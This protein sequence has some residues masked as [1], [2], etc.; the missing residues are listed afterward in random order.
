MISPIPS[1]SFTAPTAPEHQQ[2]ELLKQVTNHA[3]SPYQDFILILILKCPLPNWLFPLEARFNLFNALTFYQLPI[4]SNQ[5]PNSLLFMIFITFWPVLFILGVFLIIFFIIMLSRAILAFL[6]LLLKQFRK[7]EQLTFLELTFPADTSKSAYATEQLFTLFHTLARRQSP[8]QSFLK[9][10]KTYSLEIVS[11]RDNGIRYVLVAPTKEA[12]IVKRSLFSYLPGLKIR[13]MSDYL[14]ITHVATAANLSDLDIV[15]LKQFGHFALPLKD[16][17]ALS[18]H[19]PI[20]YVTG[21]LTKLRQGELISFQVAASPILSSVHKNLISQMADLQLKIRK[22]LP[23]N[24]ILNPGITNQLASLPLVSLIV[25]MV[26]IFGKV[27]HLGLLFVI[28][29]PALILDTSGKTVPILMTTPISTNPQELLNPYEQELQTI[30]KEKI[31][32]HLFETSIRIL[33]VAKDSD[34]LKLRGQELIAAFGPF[35]KKYQSLVTKRSV[36]SSRFV[37][38][39]RLTQFRSRLLSLSTAFNQNP[40]LSASEISDIYHFPYTD[41]TKTEGLLKSKSKELPA[42]LSLKKSTTQFDVIIG[43]SH[44]GGETIPI[45]LTKEQRQKHTYIVGKTGTGKTTML[46]NMIFQD[47]V[48]GK[49]L[50]VLDPHGDLIKELLSLI[51]QER[52]KDIIYFDPSD[53]DFPIG[54]N[55]LS[56]GIK[57]DNID[58]EQEW[59]TSSVISVFL[60]LTPKEYWGH[61]L[62]HILRNAT[63][64]ALQTPSPTLLTIQRLLTDRI[65]QKKVSATLADPILKQFWEKEFKLFGSMQQAAAI[66]PLTNRIGKFITTKMTRHILLQEKSTISIQKIMDEGKILLVNLS[67]GDLGEDE[68]FF[69]GTILTS[70]I[71]MAAYQRIKISESKRRDFFLYIDEFQN[72]ATRTFGELMSEGRKF[73]ISLIPSHQNIAQIEDKNLLETIAGNANNIICLGASP[74]DEAFILP[75]MEPEVEKGEI[76]NLAPYQFF[77]KTKNEYSEDAFSG[78]TIK[79]DVEE[80]EKIKNTVIAN[81]RKSYSLPRKEVEEYIEKLFDG[82]ELGAGKTGSPRPKKLAI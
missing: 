47:I 56:P 55:I 8:V 81:T 48:S 42:P 46:K 57:F 59:I 64:T 7:P 17:K 65:Y 26:K 40:I 73:H 45:G 28:S 37:F 44:Y 78:E 5:H 52:I 35:T 54:I 12:E 19:D 21:A 33:I 9:H 68:S 51:P 71:Q 49:G 6:V 15:E 30:V 38:K 50:A 58:D 67:K 2:F 36:L 76:V 75:Y 63:L 29:L 24:P 32:Q 72:F 61:R 13:D 39:Q 25:I 43:A 22:G 70:F 77:I 79:L 66:A 41:I 74:A 10:K 18:E 3:L 4:I 34:E 14:D 27:L 31:S 62:E 82:K 69:F 16:Q 53:R 11:S 1:P 23:I 80:D 20:A 60:K